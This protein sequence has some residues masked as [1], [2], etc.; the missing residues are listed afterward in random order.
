MRLT[1]FSAASPGQLVDTVKGAKAFLPSPFP[2]NLQLPPDLGRLLGEAHAALGQLNEAARFLP[3][4]DLF[5]RPLQKSEA[6]LSSRIEGTRTT[7]EEA[8]AQEAS[9]LEPERNTDAREV[10]N[11]ERALHGGIDAIEKG[12]SLSLALIKDLHGV[13]MTEVRG[14]DKTPGVYRKEQ[15][16]I[17]PEES[18]KD[19]HRARFIPPPWEHV[20][21][22]MDGL[23]QQIL[24]TTDDDPLIRLALVHYQF[25]TIHPFG[26]GNGR[27]GRLLISLQSIRERLLDEPWLYVSPYLE[28]HKQEYYDLL[29][30]TSARGD[31]LAWIRF[32][33]TAVRESA[34]SILKKIQALRALYNKHKSMLSTSQSQKPVLLLEALQATPFVTV[35][36]AQ[37]A[38]ESKTPQTAKAAI[39]KLIELGILEETTWKPRGLAGRPPTVYKCE[40]ILALVRD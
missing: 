2:V 15:V 20:Q 29:Y 19:I 17:G 30:N 5:T 26:D 40:E 14:K 34:R 35:A 11:Y 7:L 6:V 24:A 16:W 21:S 27:T 32:F 38:L 4:P 1:D 3:N 37:V 18:R 8:F 28:A 23:E 12:R 31:Y 9:G 33:I 22:C 39:E 36:M 10:R 25:E 13:L